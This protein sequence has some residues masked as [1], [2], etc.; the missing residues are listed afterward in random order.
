MDAAQHK[1]TKL[2]KTLRDFLCVIMCGP[3]QLSFQCGP[4]PLKG[5]TP[6]QSVLLLP[7]EEMVPVFKNKV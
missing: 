4:E 3:K 1:I 7:A 2:L 5:R 6:L